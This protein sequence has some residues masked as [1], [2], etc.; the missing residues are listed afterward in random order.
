MNKN[1][2]KICPMLRQDSLAIQ[3]APGIICYAADILPECD[4]ANRRCGFSH[5][6]AVILSYLIRPM[7]VERY[8]ILLIPLFIIFLFYPFGKE[9][10]FWLGKRDFNL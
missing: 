10:C 3:Q 1:K 7:L 9:L 2:T 5:A 8:L 6:A 4:T